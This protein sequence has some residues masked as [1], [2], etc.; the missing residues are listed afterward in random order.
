MKKL[1]SVLL[2]LAISICSFGQS[3]ELENHELFLKYLEME[4]VDSIYHVYLK[5][6]ASDDNYE[7]ALLFRN[8]YGW[9]LNKTEELKKDIPAIIQLSGHTHQMAYERIFRPQR[10]LASEWNR[11]YD[12]AQELENAFDISSNEYREVLAIK[13]KLQFLTRNNTG[14]LEDLPKLLNLLDS[15]SNEHTVMLLQYGNALYGSG[16]MEMAKKIFENGP[17]SNPSFLW[18]LINIYSNDKN[19]T[20]IINRKDQILVDSHGIKLYDLG[21]AYLETG[22]RKEASKYFSIFISKFE[23]NKYEPVVRIKRDNY[24]HSITAEQLEKL[25]D[26]YFSTDTA[27]SCKM[28]NDAI[29]VLN[30]PRNNFFLE[31]QITAMTDEVKKK[32]MRNQLE[33]MK[34]EKEALLKKIKK[35]VKRCK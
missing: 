30:T 10:L 22:N 26:F 29:S 5:V 23:Y 34:K 6:T 28:Y 2:L 21:F 24:V 7:E 11:F 25:G 35:K 1:T 9:A 33:E 31:K 32:E 27:L 4:K 19:Y 18:T 12:M 3:E 15:G 16:Q 20:E 13:T 17:S 14:L 8:Q